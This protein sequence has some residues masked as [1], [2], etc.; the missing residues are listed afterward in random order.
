MGRFWWVASIVVVRIVI[1]VVVL[2]IRRFINVDIV[3]LY[4]NDRLRE[5]VVG[6]VDEIDSD[7]CKEKYEI[8]LEFTKRR[9]G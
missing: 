7:L 8:L 5:E 9:K 6:F 2:F 4:V 1:I 3:L